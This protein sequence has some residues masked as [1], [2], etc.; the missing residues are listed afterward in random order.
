MSTSSGPFGLLGSL[1]ILVLTLACLSVIFGLIGL[2]IWFKHRQLERK[3]T[4]VMREALQEH[5]LADPDRFKP[6]G[7]A[8]SAA[9]TLAKRATNW[10]PIVDYRMGSPRTLFN[11]YTVMRLDLTLKTEEELKLRLGFWGTYLAEVNPV[12]DE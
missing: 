1:R 6:R 8:Q 7:F 9:E 5:N 12:E 2:S 11:G 3:I 4:P 10:T